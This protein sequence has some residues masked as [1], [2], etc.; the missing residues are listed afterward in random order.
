MPGFA[1]WNLTQVLSTCTP[2]YTPFRFDVEVTRVNDDTD[3]EEVIVTVTDAHSI[4]PGIHPANPGGEHPRDFT[5]DSVKSWCEQCVVFAGTA[6][7]AQDSVSINNLK[8][9]ATINGGALAVLDWFALLLCAYFVGLTMAAEVKDMALVDMAVQRSVG[10]LSTG[11]QIAFTLL[12]RFRMHFLLTPLL[13]AIPV[14]ILSQGG[15]ALGT[16]FN[17]IAVLFLTEVKTK[18]SELSSVRFYDLGNCAK[19]I[20]TVCSATVEQNLM[21]VMMFC[22]RTDRLTT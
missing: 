17:T 15:G 8:Q 20:C 1:G 18:L 16:C 5:H 2:P 9:A 14:V 12:G 7:L 19:Q 11:W 3:D 21:N 6:P 22:V 4:P 13:S 10:H